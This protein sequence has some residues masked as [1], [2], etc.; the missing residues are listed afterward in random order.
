MKERQETTFS[1]SPPP[2][3]AKI[4][5]ARQKHMAIAE[6]CHVKIARLF[7][8]PNFRARKMQEGKAGRPSGI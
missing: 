3:K 4:R 6:R 2:L 5:D 1:L 7:A 8:I